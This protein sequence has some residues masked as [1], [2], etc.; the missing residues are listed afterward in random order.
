MFLCLIDTSQLSLQSFSSCNLSAAKVSV[1]VNSTLHP[2]ATG[3]LQER[4]K[5]LR[6][7]QL[8]VVLRRGWRDLIVKSLAATLRR[9]FAKVLALPTAEP[10]DALG[11]VVLLA[12]NHELE[13]TEEM[14][15]SPAELARDPYLRW[16]SSQLNHAWDNRFVPKIDGVNTSVL[17][18]DLNPSELRAER[19]NLAAR[20]HL[21]EYLSR[22]GLHW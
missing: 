15:L 7:E 12:A 9:H 10:P 18:D 21:H 4:R 20:R 3:S 14:L 13:V 17:T 22:R 11:N 19:I 16:H 2:S 6:Y 1:K 5:N 8:I